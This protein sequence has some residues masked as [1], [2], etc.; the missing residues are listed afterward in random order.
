MNNILVIEDDEVS[1]KL[2]T[3]LLKGMY[4]NVYEASNGLEGYEIAQKTSLEVVITDMVMPC[5]N[6]FE[7]IL[8]IKHLHNHIRIV[9]M[10]GNLD[11]LKEAGFYGAHLTLSKP[12]NPQEFRKSISQ[13]VDVSQRLAI[14]YNTYY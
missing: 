13:I 11:L 1:R 7:T 14:I 8:D 10:S 9:A 2:L 3:R 12:I 6:G 4:L 5:Q